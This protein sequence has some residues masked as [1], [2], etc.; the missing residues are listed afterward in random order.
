MSILSDGNNLIINTTSNETSIICRS[1]NTFVRNLYTPFGFLIPANAITP[2]N[3]GKI[4]MINTIT[5]GSG[6][7]SSGIKN[8]DATHVFT[9]PGIYLI[10]LYLKVTPGSVLV[11]T[12]C[13]IGLSTSD[14]T[15]ENGTGQINCYSISSVINATSVFVATFQKVINVV[16][17]TTSHYFLVNIT[18]SG[19]FT[20]ATSDCYWKYIKIG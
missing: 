6:T 15:F 5:S 2:L 4:G 1:T 9:S 11:I 17:S 16:D 14:T 18:S 20:Y 8:L 3:D 7:I 12:N 13:G 19:S 10:N